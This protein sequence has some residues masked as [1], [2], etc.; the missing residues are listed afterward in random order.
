MACEKVSLAIRRVDWDQPADDHLR[1]VPLASPVMSLDYY[2]GLVVG[3]E[4]NLAGVF[5]LEGWRVGT[6]CYQ[7]SGADMGVEYHILA[8]GGR[9]PG[10]DLFSATLPGIEALAREA[11]A[12]AV[13]IHTARPGMVK[14]LGGFGYDLSEVIC[15]KVL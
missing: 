8:A 1:R 14:R 11:G 7:I 5:T 12:G 9:L 2:E 3:G 4:A 15:R 6:V 10:V 13:R